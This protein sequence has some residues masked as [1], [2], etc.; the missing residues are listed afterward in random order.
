MEV[1]PV[2]DAGVNSWDKS[3]N[4]ILKLKTVGGIVDI[5][6]FGILKACERASIIKVDTWM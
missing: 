3:T 2:A 1:L 6:S 4:E 5:I